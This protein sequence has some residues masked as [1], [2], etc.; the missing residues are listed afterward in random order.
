ML[1]VL[2]DKAASSFAQHHAAPGLVEGAGKIP[3]CAV[4]VRC[5]CPTGVHGGVHTRVKGRFRPP[6]TTREDCP[7]LIHS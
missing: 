6:A 4:F 2:K 1:V 7:D 5:Q 3:D